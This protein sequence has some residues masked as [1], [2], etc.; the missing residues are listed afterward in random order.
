MK[1]QQIRNACLRIGFAGQAFQTDPWL[2]PKGSMGTFRQIGLMV[3]TGAEA[4]TPMPMAELPMPLEQALEGVDACIVTHVHPDHIGT[5]PDGTVGAPPGK[6]VPVFVQS[7]EDRAVME[8][9]GFAEVHVFSGD[10]SSFN[11]V[12]LEKTPGRRGVISP[13]GPSWAWFYSILP[14]RRSTLPA[15]W[16]GSRAWR[17]R[18]PASSRR[19]LSSMPAASG[20]AKAPPRP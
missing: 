20:R 15:A 7:A 17:K 6:S 19:S 12:K 14:K 16:S 1:I 2:A 13:C 3:Y 10:V 4:G 8:R 5:A 11:G 9:S 18:S